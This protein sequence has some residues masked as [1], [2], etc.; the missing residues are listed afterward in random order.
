M[1]VYELFA[2]G[3]EKENYSTPQDMQYPWSPASR[4]YTLKHAQ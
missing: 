3:T 4:K 2:V 1:F